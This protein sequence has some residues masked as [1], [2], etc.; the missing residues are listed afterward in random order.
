M[1]NDG[2]TGAS[3]SGKKTNIIRLA[4]YLH[5]FQDAYSPYWSHI[6]PKV[7][8]RRICSTIRNYFSRW[9]FLLFLWPHCV[10]QGWYCKEKL[11]VSHS[12][13]SNGYLHVIAYLLF[14]FL[15]PK[16]KGIRCFHILRFHKPEGHIWYLVPNYQG[17]ILL[18]PVHLCC[19][20]VKSCCCKTFSQSTQP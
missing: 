1:V 4:K 15:L 20:R 11:D 9:S 10:I 17:Y 6:F 19:L 2:K 12:W 8:T 7:L 13:G 18:F 16:M 5:Q 14:L 3:G